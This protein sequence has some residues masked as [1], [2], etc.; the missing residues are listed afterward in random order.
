MTSKRLILFFV[1][2]SQ[3]AYSAAK[4]KNDILCISSDNDLVLIENFLEASTEIEKKQLGETGKTP[5]IL[6]ALDVSIG[7]AS[8]LQNQKGYFSLRYFSSKEGA[9]RTLPSKIDQPK[10]NLYDGDFEYRV[11]GFDTSKKAWM[12]DSDL[13]VITLTPGFTS[14]GLYVESTM[15]GGKRY[16]A[17]MANCHAVP[18]DID[19]AIL[20]DFPKVPWECALDQVKDHSKTI[21]IKDMVDSE[22]LIK[23][24]LNLNFDF[25]MAEHEYDLGIH[26][27]MTGKELLACAKAYQGSENSLKVNIDLSGRGLSEEIYS[28]DKETKEESSEQ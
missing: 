20:W 28:S 18:S 23:Y 10:K 3:G 25:F 22:G 9:S 6:P 15:T 19:P 21:E 16:S 11:R 7:I 5:R 8:S 1:L 27:K 2:I 12:E 4:N 26:R 13:S 17:K 24:F 14:P